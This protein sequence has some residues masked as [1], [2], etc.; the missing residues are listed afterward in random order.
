[1]KLTWGVLMVEN[2]ISGTV[3]SFSFI[4]YLPI[5]TLKLQR[6]KKSSLIGSNSNSMIV[7]QFLLVLVNNS[8]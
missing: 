7:D 6:K 4:F 3:N 8:M 1:M 2:K 5:I